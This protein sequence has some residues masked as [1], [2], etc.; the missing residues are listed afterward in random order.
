MDLLPQ[1]GPR[2][3]VPERGVERVGA[4]VETHIRPDEGARADGDET[5]V[6][7]GAVEVD[8]DA[9]GGAQVG[10]VVDVDGG[11]DPGVGV[12]EGVVFGLR[13]GG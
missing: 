7:D 5:R 3:P 9:G 10:A 13:C 6:E 8:E 1:L 11:L 12:E 4:G 2:R